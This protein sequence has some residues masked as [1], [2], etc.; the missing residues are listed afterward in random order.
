MEIASQIEVDWELAT[1][2][3][4]PG[5]ADLAMAFAVLS[6]IRRASV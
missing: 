3:Y 2:I 4:S 5:A 6:S 1:T